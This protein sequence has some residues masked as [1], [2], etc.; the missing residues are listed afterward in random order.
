MRLA[1][2]V[3]VIRR[4][5]RRRG[6]IVPDHRVALESLLLR[7]LYAR[8]VFRLTLLEPVA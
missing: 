5:V 6:V 3:G 7:Q 8:F 2:D 4:R 1:E